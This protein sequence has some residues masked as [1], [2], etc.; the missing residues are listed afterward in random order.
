[1]ISAGL[2]DIIRDKTHEL[3]KINTAIYLSDSANFD[4]A[5]NALFLTP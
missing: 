2:R 3:R 5:D 1:M 4:F